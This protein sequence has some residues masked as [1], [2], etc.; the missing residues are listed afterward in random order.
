MTDST[1]LLGEP[2]WHRDPEAAP[3]AQVGRHWAF[4][5]T[6]VYVIGRSIIVQRRIGRGLLPIWVWVGVT[7]LGVVVAFSSVAT[8][9]MELL[10]YSTPG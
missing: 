7:L 8:S 4:L 10:G 2:R 1:P 6:G 9:V 3:G 5:S